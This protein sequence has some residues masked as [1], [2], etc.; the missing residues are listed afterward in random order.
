IFIL[1]L[2]YFMNAY[3]GWPNF[4]TPEKDLLLNLHA[5][6]ISQCPN[7]Q[8]KLITDFSINIREHACK[9]F[10]PPTWNWV[11]H[12]DEQCHA[13]SDFTFQ[14]FE[15]TRYQDDDGL[16]NYSLV[17]AFYSNSSLFL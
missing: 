12:S 10:C 11:A 8:G 16:T 6:D 5:I 7:G 9:T 17:T 2:F 13:L 15:V 14:K 4:S 3:A 1:T